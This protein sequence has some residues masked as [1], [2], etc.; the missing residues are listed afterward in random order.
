M[1]PILPLVLALIMFLINPNG[2]NEVLIVFYAF[3]PFLL[4][5]GLGILLSV[6]ISV[7]FGSKHGKVWLTVVVNVTATII[8]AMFSKSFFWTNFRM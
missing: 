5:G 8:A 7:M 1:W 6:V 4:W 3:G 2:V